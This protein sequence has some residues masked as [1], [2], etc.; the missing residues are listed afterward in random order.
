MMKPGLLA[1]ALLF[2]SSLWA[3]DP[4]EITVTGHELPAELK[5]V[6]VDEKLGSSLD[7]SLPFTDDQG[8]TGPIGRFF[9]KDKPVLMAMVYYSCPSLCNY[10]LNGLTDTL[11]QLQWKTGQEFELVAV[12]MNSSE[13][14]QLASEK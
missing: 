7:L 11:K 3:Y 1:A 13:N 10:H 12:S 9:H 8:V 14:A 6:G 5:E 2:S 4:K